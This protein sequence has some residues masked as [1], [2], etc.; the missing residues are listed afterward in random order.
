MGKTIKLTQKQL[1][2]GEEAFKFIYSSDTPICNGNS[3][4]SVAGKLNNKEDGDAFT[5]DKFASM[6]CPQ[7]YN[8]YGNYGYRY[9]RSNEL[10]ED[11][12]NDEDNDGVDDFYNNDEIDIL[13]DYD[14]SNNLTK[15]PHGVETKTNVLLNACQSLTPKQKAIVLN[16]ILETWDLSSLGYN[17]KK[18]LLKKVVVKGDR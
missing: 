6:N 1:K 15:I 11:A 12:N 2:E 7:A 3:E 17:I 9:G 10:R 4:I 18:L 14:K 13:G 5:T 16:K 8:R